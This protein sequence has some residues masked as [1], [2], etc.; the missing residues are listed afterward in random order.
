MIWVDRG[1][2]SASGDEPG[3]LGEEVEGSGDGIEGFGEEVDGSWGEDVAIE[4]GLTDV[5]VEVR[6]VV[7]AGKSG[8]FMGS[9]DS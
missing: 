4:A 8:E 3:G 2:V 6:W 7:V 5:P 1:G 9:V